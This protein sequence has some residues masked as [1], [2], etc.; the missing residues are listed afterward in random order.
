MADFSS[1]GAGAGAGA[2]AAAAAGVS[3]AF[4]SSLRTAPLRTMAAP[5][6]KRKRLDDS[7]SDSDAS[8]K[9]VEG[10]VVC[11]PQ[12]EATDFDALAKLALRFKDDPN[13]RLLPMPPAAYDALKIPRPQAASLMDAAINCLTRTSTHAYSSSEI[14]VRDLSKTHTEADFPKFYEGPSHPHMLPEGGVRVEVKEAAAASGGAGAG[15][16]SRAMAIDE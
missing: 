6:S 8:R 11:P 10:E 3:T 15:A 9:S 1:F 14:E 13:L 12:M 16:G 5:L 4:A 2:A 7:D